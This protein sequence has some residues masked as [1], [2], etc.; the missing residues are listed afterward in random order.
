[1]NFFTDLILS[2]PTGLTVAEQVKWKKERL[3]ISD[4]DATHKIALAFFLDIDHSKVDPDDKVL[5]EKTTGF[6]W[7]AGSLTAERLCGA[8]DSFLHSE[9]SHALSQETRNQIS[10]AI[11]LLRETQDQSST[12]DLARSSNLALP[13]VAITGSLF[14]ENLTV[15][16]VDIEI[17]QALTSRAIFKTK[18]L[19]LG[20]KVVFLIGTLLH[21]TL[22]S[23]ELTHSDIFEVCHYDT[24][25]EERLLVY[26]IPNAESN[27]LLQKE[28]WEKLYQ[29]KFTKGSSDPVHAHLEA[30]AIQHKDPL[31]RYAKVSKQKKNTCHFRCLLAFLKDHVVRHSALNT[32]DEKMIQ[33]R[34]FK[35]KFGQFLLDE[36]LIQDRTLIACST[37]RQNAR[38]QSTRYAIAA[39][40]EIQFEK[41]C[42]A[43][44]EAAQLL[45]PHASPLV[46]QDDHM[47]KSTYLNGCHKELLRRLENSLLTME[48][49]EKLYGNI[50]D[51]GVQKTFETYKQRCE[52]RHT[53][54]YRQLQDELATALSEFQLQFEEVTLSIYSLLNEIDKKCSE[55]STQIGIARERITWF[56]PQKSAVSVP[57]TEQEL[58]HTLQ[59]LL[60]NPQILTRLGQ[61]P[62]IENI[63][64]QA[65]QQAKFGELA[66]IYQQMAPEDQQRFCRKCNEFNGF[67]WAPILSIA[68]AHLTQYPDTPYLGIACTEL[69]QRAIQEHDF[70]KFLQLVNRSDNFYYSKI[71]NSLCRVEIE[72]EKIPAIL[73]YL[74]ELELQQR[75]QKVAFID[76]MLNRIE[77]SLRVIPLSIYKDRVFKSERINNL[78]NRVHLSHLYRDGKFQEIEVLLSECVA[79]VRVELDPYPF[80]LHNWQQGISL[81]KNPRC[82]FKDA[83]LKDL[84]ISS[85]THDSPEILL[86]ALRIYDCEPDFY[87]YYTYPFNQL[88]FFIKHLSNE[89]EWMENGILNSV[90][91]ALLYSIDSPESFAEANKICEGLSDAA[92]RKLFQNLMTRKINKYLEK[93][94]ETFLGKNLLMIKLK[95]E[96]SQLWIQAAI[97]ETLEHPSYIKQRRQLL[98][99]LELFSSSIDFSDPLIVYQQLILPIFN[100]PHYLTES[101]KKNLYE[102]L[103][104]DLLKQMPSKAL[105]MG[106]AAIYLKSG[107]MDVAQKFYPNLSQLPDYPDDK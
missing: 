8:L 107:E 85:Y 33:W 15:F 89:K 67:V 60:Q 58:N 62:H 54:F 26:Q 14:W 31:L 90:L 30:L 76:T 40:Q 74:E 49:L 18:Q 9:E 37:K 22:L 45:N 98:E 2:P 102:A 4:T 103:L 72:E 3:A 12:I 75:D 59:L 68:E 10:R 42:L 71:E 24:A 1:M 64:L 97:E 52:N 61:R 39:T 91:Q 13:L 105:Q 43:Y 100:R 63:L 38:Y 34:L 36:G 82:P 94:P 23:I 17:V 66:S 20:E 81:L 99:I 48:Q 41:S 55:I 101:D 44:K 69:C 57:L 27:V 5:L 16:S 50:E 28:F 86:D 7:F 19:Q 32:L 47:P 53:Y 79:N 80:S 6:E 104:F 11:F 56:A 78:L 83:L 95:E 106:L 77:R 25:S 84:L 51:I 88:Q 70:V 29:L 21:E 65:I 35:V 46:W 92:I 73:D 87:I 93:Y 96:F